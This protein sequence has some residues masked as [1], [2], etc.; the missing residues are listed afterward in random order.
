MEKV[1]KPDKSPNRV[2]N[3]DFIKLAKSE[4]TIIYHIAKHKSNRVLMIRDG[5][6]TLGL[7]VK[8]ITSQIDKSAT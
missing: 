2:V 5:L 6:R 4:E 8:G 1:R 7:P 3:Q